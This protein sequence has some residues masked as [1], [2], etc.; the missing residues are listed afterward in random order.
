MRDVLLP[1]TIYVKGEKA[2][3][4]IL[5]DPTGSNRIQQDPS[6]TV[7]SRQDPTGSKDPGSAFSPLR[8]ALV[9]S[10]KDLRIEQIIKKHENKI[11]LLC[12]WMK[13]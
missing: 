13:R 5:Q 10:A 12:P 11:N 3:P 7:R 8:R 1:Y 4:R 9:F 2:D 6:G